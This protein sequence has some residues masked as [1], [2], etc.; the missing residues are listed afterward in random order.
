MI[1][2]IDDHRQAHGVEPICRVLPIAPSTYHEH[3]A[4]RRDPARRPARLQRDEA[5]RPEVLRVI[6]NGKGWL[7]TLNEGGLLGKWVAQGE[8]RAEFAF[9]LLNKGVVGHSDLVADFM[10]QWWNEDTEPRAAELVRWLEKLYPDGPIGSVE[11]LYGDVLAALPAADIKAVLFDNFQLGSWV[12]KSPEVGARIL[13]LWLRK[14]MEVF[15]DEH[16]FTDDRMHDESYWIDELAKQQ[17]AAL[18]EAVVGP[19]ATAL[20][21]ETAALVEGTLDYSCQD[22]QQDA[23]PAH[24]GA[25]VAQS[26]RRPCS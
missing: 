15:P 18:L 14:W 11:D 4:R 19:L 2:F 10:R 23:A 7:L 20:E 12:H 24:H 9:W 1:A 21:R 3:L 25:G 8:A 22:D 5:L 6:F 16:P 17:P 13:G 26:G